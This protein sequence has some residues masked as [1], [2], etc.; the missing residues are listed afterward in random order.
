MDENMEIT[1]DTAASKAGGL[2]RLEGVSQIL[3]AA[4]RRG[5]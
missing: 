5:L 2:Q 3:Q 1:F 4:T